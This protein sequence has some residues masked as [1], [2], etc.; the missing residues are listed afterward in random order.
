MWAAG[1]GHVQATGLLLE[2]GAEVNVQD[3]RGMSPLM[4]A[5]K[6]GEPGVVAELVEAG[7]DRNL[8]DKQGLTA[9]DYA[10]A[11]GYAQIVKILQE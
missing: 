7:A 11:M 1:Y 3:D 5:S 2:H 9:L 8:K 6:A 10:G 4:L